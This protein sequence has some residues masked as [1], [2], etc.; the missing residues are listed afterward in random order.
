MP[1]WFLKVDVEDVISV[2]YYPVF[3]N[4]L[5]MNQ[6]TDL[7]LPLVFCSTRSGFLE[8]DRSAGFCGSDV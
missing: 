5:D 3:E 1:L 2:G 4:P 7:F 6:K 8:S